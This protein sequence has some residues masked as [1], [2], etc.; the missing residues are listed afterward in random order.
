M[1]L[2]GTSWLMVLTV[3]AG[4]GQGQALSQEPARDGARLVRDTDLKAEPYTDAKA[5]AVLAENLRVTVL[6][7]SA[8]WLQV[9]VQVHAQDQTGW[10]KMFSVRWDSQGTP[11]TS[12]TDDVRKLFN[13]ATTGSS[14]STVTTASRGLDEGKLIHPSPNPAALKAMLGFN[15]SGSD[16]QAFADELGL[17]AQQLAYRKAIGGKS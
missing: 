14:G 7:R 16:A 17:K 4:I 1:K 6:S 9:Q 12:G 8:S 13:L 15:V 2:A 10:V 11:Q 5:L 3:A